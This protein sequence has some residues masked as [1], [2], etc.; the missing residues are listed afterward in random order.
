MVKDSTSERSLLFIIVPH[1]LRVTA[2]SLMM[3][4]RHA[5]TL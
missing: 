4:R 5:V 2:A 1:W 3:A